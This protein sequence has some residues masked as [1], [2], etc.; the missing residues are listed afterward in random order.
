MHTP[1]LL[2]DVLNGLKLKQDGVYIDATA[3][4]GGHLKEIAKRSRKVLALERNRAQFERL[5]HMKLRKKTV[6]VQGNFADIEDI[7]KKKGFQEADGVLFDLGVSFWE[8]AYLERGLSY[9]KDNERLDMRLGES[10]KESASDVLN[11]YTSENLYEIFSRNA[12]EPRSKEI[13]R[14]I[15]AQRR[16]KRLEN[17]A[18]LKR[19]IKTVLGFEDSR[20]YARIFQ[21]LRMHINNE[22]ENLKKGLTGATRLLKKGGRL[23]VLSFHSVEDRIV[24]T[25]MKKSELK[26]ITKR[27]SKYDDLSFER[28]TTLRVVEKI[29]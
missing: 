27:V 8:L 22:K 21:A 2:K 19:A 16:K 15:T 12:E 10:T 14:A 17:V 23:V 18:D 25:N 28:S 11:T 7:A 9:R 13:A 29:L 5:Q 4:D 20:T 6:F 3:G 1:V 26:L 24:K